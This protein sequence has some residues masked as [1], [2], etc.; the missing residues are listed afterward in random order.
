M[1]FK[2]TKHFVF[3]STKFPKNN[4]Y[5]TLKNLE[6][7]IVCGHTVNIHVCIKEIEY[8]R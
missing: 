1:G 7:V 6:I 5:S 2:K 8:I 3:M 4:L